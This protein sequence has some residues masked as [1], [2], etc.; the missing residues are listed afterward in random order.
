MGSNNP[1]MNIELNGSVLRKADSWRCG[2]LLY[3]MI[4]GKSPKII[5]F[6]D[7]PQTLQDV[8]SDA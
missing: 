1:L 3:Q 2:V 8:L 5:K 7:V 4:T 6:N